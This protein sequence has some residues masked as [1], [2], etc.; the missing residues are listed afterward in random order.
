MKTQ[1]ITIEFP[2]DLLIALNE[3][4]SELKKDIKT[5]LAIRLYRMQKLS[6]GKAAQIAGLSRFDFESLLSENQV[7]ISNLTL[8]DI[9]KDTEK[10]K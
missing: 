4:E 8:D 10:L 5:T 3:S 1:T 6:I 2:S 9:I 7:P